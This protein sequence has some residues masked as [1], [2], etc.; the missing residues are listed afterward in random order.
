MI[1]NAINVLLPI[2][3]VLGLGYVAGRTH[4][5]DADQVQGINRLV[6]NYAM[7]AMMFVA[8]VSTT[9]SE[10]LA[11]AP[12]LLALLGAFVGTFAL[13]FLFSK[14]VLR[15][16]IG[17]AALQANLTSYPSVAFFGPPIFRGL[18]GPASLLSTASAAVLSVIT[19]VPLTVALVEIH[20]QRTASGAAG[21][22][23]P[24]LGS[25]LAASLERTFKQPMVLLPLIGAALVLADVR[26]PQVIDNMLLLIGS[27]TS[28]ASIF[29]AGLVI[30]AYKLKVNAEVIGNVAVKMIVQPALMA[31][32]VA[33]IGV[34]SPLNREGILIC[35]I[36]TAVFAPLLAPRY[37]V[38]EA[39]SASTLMLS[40]LA[41]IV[42]LPLAILLTGG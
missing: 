33:V 22:S 29:L 28:G 24:S 15:H 4:K 30:A 7:P 21:D 35:A 6:L 12:F 19:I 16:S 37:K 3:F 42:T 27:A 14:F 26:V 18:F 39:E 9:R 41:M 5:F 40:A 38:Y 11:E 23:S 32:L 10:L 34:A 20:S 17:E 8:T 31:L 25:L 13:V 1:L 36:P 2:F